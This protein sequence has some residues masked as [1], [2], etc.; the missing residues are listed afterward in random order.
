MAK[1]LALV[2]SG[3][4]AVYGMQ[5]TGKPKDEC[6][7]SSDRVTAWCSPADMPPEYVSYDCSFRVF[8]NLDEENGCTSYQYASPT[9]LKY[10]GRANTVVCYDLK[11]EGYCRIT[12]VDMPGGL[13][14]ATNVRGQGFSTQAMQDMIILKD[15]RSAARETNNAPQALMFT[16]RTHLF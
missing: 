4:A 7:S 3:V 6:G 12:V 11:G 9:G 14:E 5:V 15:L 10:E 2:Y 13:L 8:E 1:A 16:L